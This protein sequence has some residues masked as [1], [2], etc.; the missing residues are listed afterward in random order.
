MSWAGSLH[1]LSGLKDTELPKPLFDKDDNDGMEPAS[2]AF[3]SHMFDP[4]Q[5][6]CLVCWTELHGLVKKTQRMTAFPFNKD[7]STAANGVSWPDKRHS[8]RGAVLAS[9]LKSY[10]FLHGDVCPQGEASPIVTESVY[11]I[12]MVD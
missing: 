6:T 1:D 5:D 9:E 12:T 4:G 2:L 11:T 7:P 8:Q 3:R 10:A